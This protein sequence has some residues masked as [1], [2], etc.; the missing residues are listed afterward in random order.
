M[1]STSGSAKTAFCIPA[2]PWERVGLGAMRKRAAELG[3]H[4]EWRQCR[5]A[6]TRVLVADDHQIV[7]RGLVAL[8]ASMPDM[9]LVATATPGK[10]PG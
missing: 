5:A 7:T 2:E 8:L 3:A 6:L 10:W 4:C 1:P 9:S